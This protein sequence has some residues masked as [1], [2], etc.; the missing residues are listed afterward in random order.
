LD[1]TNKIWYDEK[2]PD[3][4]EVTLEKLYNRLMAIPFI[5]KICSLPI[6]NKLTTYEA[7][8]YIFFGAVTTLVNWASYLL[9]KQA[10]LQ[11]TA[12]ATTVAWVIAVLFAYFVNKKY[13]FKSHQDTIRALLWEFALFIIARL[14]S[15]AFDLAFMVVTVDYLHFADGLA[16]ILSNVFVLI[17][18]Y[19]ASKIIIFKKKTA[20]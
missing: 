3:I 4:W 1:R 7:V 18:N 15:F 20:K 8:I 17:M 10:L 19:F 9:V 13:V 11:S 16:K 2:T 14:L 5:K 6:L 12:V